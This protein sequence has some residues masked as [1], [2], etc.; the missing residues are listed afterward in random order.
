MVVN[1]VMNNNSVYIHSHEFG[2]LVT[3]WL[4]LQDSKSFRCTSSV[5]SD[6]CPSVT[7]SI[8]VALCD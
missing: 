5:E 7:T 1:S 4:V 6:A 8:K 2:R 3:S